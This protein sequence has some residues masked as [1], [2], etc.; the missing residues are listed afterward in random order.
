MN[1]NHLLV[2]VLALSIMSCSRKSTLSDIQAYRQSYIQ[3]HIDDQRSPI[4][5][6]DE[7]YIHFFDNDPAWSLVC[8]FSKDDDAKLFDMATYSGITKPYKVYGY[9]TCPSA[10]GDIK[11]E[12]YQSA[13]IMNYPGYENHLFLPYKDLTN[14]DSSYGG[15]RYINVTTDDIANNKLYVDFNKSYNPWC[16]YSDGYNCPIPPIANHL[17]VAIEAGEANYSGPKKKRKSDSY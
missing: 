11:L 4:K 7:A 9:L 1:I 10:F 17:D 6:G 13:N 16:A 5:S 3:K 8:D 2:I 15:G 14:G 12:I